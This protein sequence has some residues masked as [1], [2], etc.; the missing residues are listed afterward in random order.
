[1]TAEEY[2]AQDAAG[3]ASLIRSGAVTKQEVLAAARARIA[4]LNPDLNAVVRDW[5]EDEAEQAEVK[6][7]EQQ[8]GGHKDAPLAGVPTLIKDN[9]AIGGK[10][11]S[12]GSNLLR[13]NVTADSSPIV[14][15]LEQAGVIPLGRSNMCEFG[16]LP[17]TES[18]LYGPARNPW[19]P[20]FSPGG[21]SGG[22]AAAVAAGLVPI[23]H[24]NDGGGSLRIPASCCGIFALKPSRG[25]NPGGER[26][27]RGGLE[28]AITVNNVL[29]R[30]V[31]D[32]AVALDAICGPEPGEWFRLPRP[33]RPYAELIREDPKPLRIAFST[34]DL[35]GREAH[36]DCQAAVHAVVSRLAELGH[37][38]E[39]AS[40]DI[41]GEAFFNAFR[42]EWAKAAGAL[43]LQV[44]KQM[45]QGSQ[46]PGP[47]K[48]LARPRLGFK[49]ILNAARQNG[50]P[51]LE[52]FTVA[53]AEID[54]Q[55]T[56]GD[57]LIA[58][59]TM[60]AAESILATFLTTY[61][62][63]LTPVLGGPPM[64]IGE[65][66]QRWPVKRMV[67]SLYDYVG[68]TPIANTGGFPAMA[69]PGTWNARGLPIGVQ[70]LGPIAREDRL[71]QLAAQLERAYPWQR[72]LARIEH[73][74]QA[75]ASGES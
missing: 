47:L 64:A 48:W 50:M 66:D 5:S 3:L 60:Q 43:L 18:Q 68:F 57:L 44:Q 59:R 8:S 31:R 32:S 46:L 65:F 24:G 45:L 62:L 72:R 27:P 67:Q 75:S 41:D 23:A 73:P 20:A 16:L 29:S 69:V 42:L 33:Q 26:F 2:A 61:D 22:S 58:E 51:L 49:A 40:P 25:R 70:F 36:P 34:A 14:R 55:R 11:T 53:L 21:S 35:R 15:R 71:L 12:Y 28:T 63:F 74:P 9:V 13:N 54:Y 19:N 17:L 39:E 37:H 30:S 1:M 7:S 56:P 4:E 10:H 6:H 52:P 38:V